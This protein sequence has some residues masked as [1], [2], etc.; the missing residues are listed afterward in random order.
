MLKAPINFMSIF[1]IPEVIHSDQ[2]SNFMS[3]QFSRA[4]QQLKAKHNISSAYHPQSQ[5]AFEHFHQTLKSLLHSYCV[6][7]GS[8]WEEG[9]LWLL[10]TVKKIVHDS[11]GFISN[12]WCITETPSKVLDYVRGFCYHL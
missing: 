3:K 6:E 10:L 7:L 4:L 11:M 8:D 12:E 1:G 9:L 2:G 5:G